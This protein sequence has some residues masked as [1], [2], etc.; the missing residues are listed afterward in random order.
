MSKINFKKE[1]SDLFKAKK[2]VFS[3]VDVPR[4]QYLQVDGKGNP[5]TASEYTAAVEALYAMA[6][7]IKFFSKNELGKDYVV[8]PMQ[9]LWWT[10]NMEEF[11]PERK[12]EWLWTMM[13]LTPD[14]IDSETV[15]AQ[16][17]KVAAKK[18]LPALSGVR[19]ADYEE[20]FSVQVLHIGSYADEAPLIA[21]M[22]EDYIPGNGLVPDGKHHEIYLNS[23]TRVAPGKL[24]TIIRQ[25]VRRVGEGV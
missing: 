7:N 5:N 14:W 17:E 8:P 19:L 15:E 4:L 25:P 9:G 16:R 3:L 10:D 23:P 12:D 1:Y 22:H 13:I 18:D 21:R 24:R 2:G 6:Y 11:S 20:G